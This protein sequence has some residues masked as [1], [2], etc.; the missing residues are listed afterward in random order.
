MKKNVLIVGAG[1]SGEIIGREIQDK[2][3][4]LG[5]LDDNPAKKGKILNGKPI[6]GDLTLIPEILDQLSIHQIIL[7]I[8]SA[9]RKIIKNIISKIINTNIQVKIV[10]GYYHILD[11]D[12]KIDYP[13]RDVDVTDLLGRP[14]VQLDI[15]SIAHYLNNKV[16]LVTGAGGS[17]G[18]ELCKLIASVKPQKLILLGRGENSIFNIYNEL[19]ILFPNLETIYSITNITNYHSLEE[20]FK[21]YM[22]QVVFHA[23]AH[24]HVVLMENHPKEAFE[25]NV[26]GSQNVM[27]LSDKWNIERFIMISTD[28]AVEP[29]SVMGATKRISENIMNLYNDISNTT[30]CAVRFG[31]VLGSRGSVLPHFKD[32]ILR[33]GPVTVTHPDVVRYF[34]T[35]PEACQLVLQAG[36][37]ANGGEIYVLNMG[38]PVKIYDLAKFM[39]QLYSPNINKDIEIIFTGLRQGEK[40]TE[41]LSSSQ[42]DTRTTYFKD[43]FVIKSQEVN[44]SYLNH[45]N[46]L[47]IKINSISDEVFK[48]ELFDLAQQNSQESIYT[49][50]LFK[51]QI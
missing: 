44:K 24:K 38:E 12:I 3:N 48:D 21:K 32:Q 34:M 1:I 26:I 41:E 40:L 46:N 2:V 43:I 31:N 16:V 15:N 42:E 19:K 29:S 20:V 4:L 17:I 18:S 39:I 13:I 22:P 14:Q 33:G 7:S 47:K 23:A 8:P 28:K 51:Y 27:S 37:M 10:P 50:P 49:Y 9:D 6:I 35:I 45:V 5:Y 36:S 11:Q 25:N 30:F